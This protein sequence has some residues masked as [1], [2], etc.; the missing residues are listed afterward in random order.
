MKVKDLI[1]QLSR[2][3][4]NKNIGVL[5]NLVNPEDPDSDIACDHLELW[6]NGSESI[7]LFIRK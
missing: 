1:N 4:P 7:D 6:D 2:I 3:D 5:V